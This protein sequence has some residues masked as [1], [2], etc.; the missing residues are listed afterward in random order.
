MRTKGGGKSGTLRVRRISSFLAS[1]L[2]SICK[3]FSTIAFIGL[4]GSTFA[5]LGN[6][7]TRPPN[8]LDF[9]A[10]EGNLERNAGSA[11]TLQSV[12]ISPTSKA[13]IIN[14]VVVKQGEKYGES[15]LVGV[16]E[17]QVVLRKGGAEQVLKLYPGVDKRETKPVASKQVPRKRKVR[18]DTENAAAASTPGR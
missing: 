14:G 6:D 17:S 8:G 18:S 5:Q 10:A 11:M 3:C 1:Y 7:P 2:I 15:V 16:A 9:G 12:M 4:T 13:A